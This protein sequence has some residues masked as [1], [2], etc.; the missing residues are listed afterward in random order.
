[1]Y[2]DFRSSLYMHACT[3]DALITGSSDC[4]FLAGDWL[5]TTHVHVANSAN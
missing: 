2:V 3:V 1:M 4:I 5:Q